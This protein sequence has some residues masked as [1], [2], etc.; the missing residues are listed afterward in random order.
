MNTPL[1]D[2][3]FPSRKS[4]VNAAKAPTGENLGY[5]EKL[6]EDAKKI[7]LD[8][9]DFS[10]EGN[11]KPRHK[12]VEKQKEYFW[13]RVYLGTEFEMN[14]EDTVVMKDLLYDEELSTKFMFWG[15]K[16]QKN[17][18][19]ENITQYDSEE[20]KRC[21]ILMIDSQRVNL[22]SDDIPYIRTLFPLSRWFRP[23][24][25]KM[26]DLEFLHKRSGEKL[27]HYRIDF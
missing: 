18:Q 23:N 2:I 7:D 1:D 14:Q 12:V 8:R 20:D 24:Y 5:M 26:N 15:K 9:I 11:F 4:L 6:V 27:D 16:Y 25:I 17:L 21:A 19:G 3:I 10:N 22:K 13:V